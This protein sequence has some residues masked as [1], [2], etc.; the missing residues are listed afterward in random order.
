MNAF[1]P[2]TTIAPTN[3]T[4]KKERKY[5]QLAI[6][7]S[8]MQKAL[9]QTADLCGEVQLDIEAMRLFAALDAAKFM[10]VAA[11]LNKLQDEQSYDDDSR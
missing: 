1:P 3:A 9:S 11:Q 4:Q 2:T 7:L 6:S 8:R 5:A 10:T